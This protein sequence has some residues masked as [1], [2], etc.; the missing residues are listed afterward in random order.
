MRPRELLI[1]T[2]THI[3]PP[4]AFEGLSAEDAVR[5]ISGAPHS[6]AEIVG[7]LVFWQGWFI[8]RCEGRA[9][10]M[11][12][13]AAEGWPAARAEDW[14]DLQKRFI[15]DLERLVQIG[16]RVSDRRIDPALEFPPIAHYTIADVLMHVAAHNAHHLGQVITLRQMLQSWPP[17]SGGLTW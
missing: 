16:E 7:H 8:E 1:E 11:A 5:K 2:F 6:I 13:H 4:Q 15:A 10:P 12:T 14:A 9:V 17:P 3:P